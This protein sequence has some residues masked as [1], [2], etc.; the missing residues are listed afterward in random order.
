MTPTV[1]SALL[2]GTQRLRAAGIDGANRDAHILMAAALEVPQ[3]RLILAMQDDINVF[4]TKAY[5]EKLTRRITGE[6]VSHILGRRLF[7]NR[8]FAVTSDVLDP[9]PETEIL[10]AEAL[11]ENFSTV[12]DLGTGSGAILISLLAENKEATGLGTDLSESALRIAQK[13]AT[14]CGVRERLTLQHA[15]WFAGVVGQF[16]LI[17]SNP[18]YISLAEMAALQSN[19]RDFEPEMA[20]T[21][22]GDGLSAYRTISTDA[23]AFC[24]PGGRILVEIGPTQAN[25]VQ[26]LLAQGGFADIRVLCD[27][28]GR[29]RVI[30]ARKPRK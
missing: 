25:A 21:D 30:S 27:F 15:N 13:N 28:D 22:Y 24:T 10:V 16:D 8:D 19:V 9:R 20:L 6:P 23:A 5:E 29:H 12:L 7:F 14:A 2:A 26:D 3:D 11:R 4:Q 18:P 17:V 1:Q